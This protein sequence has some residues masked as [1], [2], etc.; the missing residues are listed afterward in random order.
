MTYLASAKAVLTLALIGLADATYLAVKHYVGGTV[1]CSLT[2]G[3]DTVLQSQ[4]A[5]YLGVPVALWGALYYLTIVVLTALFF[6]FRSSRLLGLIFAL[7]SGGIL[8]SGVLIY[9]QGA[10][11]GAWCAYCLV[12]AII[13]LLIFLT[14][15][16]SR[17][18]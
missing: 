8:V 6:Q 5:V 15:I 4:Y 14:L 11:L 3:C 9:V 18:A 2:E 16:F 1:P 12:S 13:T 7:T 10:V 17:P